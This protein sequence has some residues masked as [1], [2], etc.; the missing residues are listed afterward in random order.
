MIRYIIL[1]LLLSGC[2]VLQ[3]NSTKCKCSCETQCEET[4]DLVEEAL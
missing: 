3:T 4:N 1:L 2:S